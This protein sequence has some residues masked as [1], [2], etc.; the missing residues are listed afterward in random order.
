[1]SEKLTGSETSK[2]SSSSATLTGAELKKH[3]L[4]CVV[5]SIECHGPEVYGTKVFKTNELELNNVRFWD[6]KSP[7]Y[8]LGVLEQNPNKGSWC[9]H[10]VNQ[11]WKL[12][13]VTKMYRTGV[14]CPRCFGEKLAEDGK[15]CITCKGSGQRLSSR[16]TQ[17]VVYIEPDS[18]VAN[19]CLARDLKEYVGIEDDDYIG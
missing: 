18:K 2:T 9:A 4:C 5:E 11:G 8:W 7:C 3:L 12:Y 16:C 15:K 10:L 6:E 1:M 13:W 19:N 17:Y 14:V